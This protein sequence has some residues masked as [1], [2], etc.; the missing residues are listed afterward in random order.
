MFR[1]ISEGFQ[2]HQKCSRLYQEGFGERIM[3]RELLINGF[4]I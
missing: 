3:P 1:V 4:G 2:R